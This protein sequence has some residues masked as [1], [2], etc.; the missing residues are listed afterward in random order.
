MSDDLK[1]RFK[2]L[3]S[4][5]NRGSEDPARAA[6]H[7]LDRAYG[8]PPQSTEFNLDLYGAATHV[9]LLVEQG[10]RRRART[11]VPNGQAGQT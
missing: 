9:E 6:R 2:E 4:Q 3:T 1:A 7:T 5:A 10:Q 11:A 8:R